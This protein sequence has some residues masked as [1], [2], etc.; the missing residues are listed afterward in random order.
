MMNYLNMMFEQTH[1]TLEIKIPY[2]E[3]YEI[4]WRLMKYCENKIKFHDYDPDQ[5]TGIIIFN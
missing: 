2:P 4:I 5:K 1:K 3:F